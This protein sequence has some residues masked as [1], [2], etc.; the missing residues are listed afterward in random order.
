MRMKRGVAVVLGLAVC[1]IVFAAPAWAQTAATSAETNDQIVFSGHLLVAK[2]EVVDTALIFHGSATIAGTV[3]G[4]VVVFDGDA[5]VSGTVLGD[6]VAFN[7]VVTVRSGAVVDGDVVT[8]QHA[9]VEHGAT[10]RGNQQQMNARFNL[11]DLGLA[12][13]IAWWV[14]FSVSTLILGLGLLL[15]APALDGAL[16]RAFKDR[17]GASFGFGAVAFFI[18][19]VLAVALLAIVIA[20]PLGLFLLLGLALVYTCGYVAAAHV[21]GR[22]LVKPP[23]SRFLAFL[24]GWGILRVAGLVPILGGLVWTVATIAGLGAL[25]VAARRPGAEPDAGGP[26]APPAPPNPIPTPAS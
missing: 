10:I 16:S 26:Q 18:F 19:P 3:T 17:T 14:G 2:G 9:I 5:D 11:H 6:V 25:W 7:G 24:A 21:L 1:A 13:R 20:I 4:S 15:L 8:R 12:G 22:L 23:T